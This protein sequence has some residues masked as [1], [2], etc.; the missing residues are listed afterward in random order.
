MTDTKGK[1]KAAGRAAVPK[2]RRADMAEEALRKMIAESTFTELPGV[3]FLAESLGVGVPTV[4]EALQRLREEG[5]LENRGER[6]RFVV[7]REAVDQAAAAAASPVSGTRHLV[8]FTPRDVGASPHEPFWQLVS[9]LGERLSPQGW[10]LR[11]HAVDYGHDKRNR[12]PW[13]AVLSTE[14][15]QALI[16]ARGTPW[17][18]DWARECGVPTFFFGG[19]EG[20]FPVPILGYDSGHMMRET[21]R[22]LDRL[23][24]RSLA[25]PILARPAAFVKRLRQAAE[26]VAAETGVKLCLHTPTAAT[27]EPSAMRLC[28]E[29]LWEREPP[30]ALG[31]VSWYEYLAAQS[32]VTGKG[33]RIPEDVSLVSLVDDAMASW[34]TPEPTRFEYDAE[35]LA[36]VLTGWVMKPPV[37]GTTAP[38]V[39]LRGH[40][41][42]GASVGPP[43]PSTRPHRPTAVATPH[44][45]PRP[46]GATAR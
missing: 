46:A 36:V 15:P 9:R 3:R 42:A 25:V 22:Q 32:F 11:V 33:L 20:A 4:S 34:I 8:I 26:E 2:V 37:V 35:E 31:L 44:E 7:N 5:W 29:K 1:K 18:A 40:W 27:F 12:A 39:L 30:T 28:L 45:A 41:V 43:R 16:I 17:L 24:H 14:R 6:K 38:R 19:D 23:G 10:T 21:I 13:D